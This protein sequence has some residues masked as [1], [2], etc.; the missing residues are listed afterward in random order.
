MRARAR[1]LGLAGRLADDPQRGCG[2]GERG[3]RG[4]DHGH[5]PLHHGSSITRSPDALLL[6]RNS[7][8]LGICEGCFDGDENSKARQVK[9]LVDVS[10]DGNKY[11]SQLIRPTVLS[12]AQWAIWA[13]PHCAP[14]TTTS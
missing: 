1:C 9:L 14:D 4:A 12:A 8:G 6:P 3:H 5:M 13:G 11:V 10:I 2:E 7:R